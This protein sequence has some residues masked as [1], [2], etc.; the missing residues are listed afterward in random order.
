MRIIAA[1]VTVVLWGCAQERSDPS[2]EKAKEALAT[3]IR[4]PDESEARK[5]C[6]LLL[7]SSSEKEAGNYCA[8]LLDKMM[9]EGTAPR[10]LSAGMTP[11]EYKALDSTKV[12]NLKVSFYN[13]GIGLYTVCRNAQ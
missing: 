6:K 7:K 2:E 1:V 9:T 11:S 13:A 8:E 4:Q 3:L 5:A 10:S 12:R